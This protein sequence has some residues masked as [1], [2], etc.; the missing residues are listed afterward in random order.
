MLIHLD[1]GKTP[2]ENYAEV[3]AFLQT[4]QKFWASQFPD[5]PNLQ[6]AFDLTVTYFRENFIGT[7]SFDNRGLS[8]I[9]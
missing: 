1:R 8:S 6:R 2:D 5:I 7:P 4:A 9:W 3:S